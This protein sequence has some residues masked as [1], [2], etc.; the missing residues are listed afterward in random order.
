M[1]INR[2]YIPKI[3]VNDEGYMAVIKLPGSGS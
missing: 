1:P 3:K 2:L